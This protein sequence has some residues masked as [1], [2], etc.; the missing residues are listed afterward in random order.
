MK[1]RVLVWCLLLT[2]PFQIF[3]EEGLTY[4]QVALDKKYRR[5]VIA[6][7]Q[8]IWM[9][10]STSDKTFIDYDG[11]YAIIDYAYFFY[12]KEGEYVLLGSLNKNGL[13]DKNNI[14]LKQA[15]VSGYDILGMSS[16]SLLAAPLMPTMVI[17]SQSQPERIRETELFV[18][19]GFDLENDN[20]KA[21]T[22]DFFWNFEG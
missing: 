13:Y 10:Y 16:S 11:E 5:D 21:L 19:I 14:C 4:V 6:Q 18:V 17:Q 12:K 9:G 1:I 8:E 7:Y 2:G 3:A 22:L 15:A 20:L